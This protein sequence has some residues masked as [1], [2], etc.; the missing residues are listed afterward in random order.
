MCLETKLHEVQENL[1]LHISQCLEP[2][3]ED[4][5]SIKTQIT[6]SK[7]EQR[8]I[9]EQFIK[10]NGT[11]AKHTDKLHAM[12]ILRERRSIDCP[13]LPVLTEIKEASAKAVIVAETVEKLNEEKERKDEVNDRKIRNKTALIYGGIGAVVVIINFILTHLIK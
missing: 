1:R 13:N 9:K 4:I 10:L 6:K 2:L 8:G 5:N 12:D 3:K 11:V 7:M